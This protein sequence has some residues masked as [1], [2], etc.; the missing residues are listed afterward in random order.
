MAG[1]KMQPV[2]WFAVKKRSH[3]NP[4]YITMN[5]VRITEDAAGAV[6]CGKEVKTPQSR[7]YYVESR[8]CY[9]YLSSKVE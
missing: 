1:R 2:R 6:A 9:G 4:V 5:R 7:I 8:T 3:R